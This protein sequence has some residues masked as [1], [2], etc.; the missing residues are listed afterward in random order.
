MYPKINQ[1][2]EYLIVFILLILA[3][4]FRLTNLEN[5]PGLYSDEGTHIEIAQNLLDGKIQYYSLNQSTLIVGRLPLFPI[6]LSVV[7]RFFGVG[8]LQLRLLTAFLGVL[9]I[10]LLYVILKSILRSQSKS[11]PIISVFLFSIYP[12]AIVFHRLGFSYHLLSIFVLVLFWGL[13]HY[14]KT[15]KINFLILSSL[16]LG[17]GSLVDL[18]GFTF[19]PFAVIVILIKN[20]RKIPLFLFFSLLPFIIYSAIMLASHQNA[21]I[22]DL[23]FILTRTNNNLGKQIVFLFFN[24][25]E[26][27]NKD[28]WI[29]FGLLGFFVFKNKSFGLYSFFFFFISF[30]NS[31]RHAPMTG[32]SYYYFIPFFSLIIV[33]VSSFCVY[34]FERLRI[35]FEEFFNN[36]INKCMHRFL[37]KTNLIP[38]SYLDRSLSAIIVSIFIVPTL[39]FSLYQLNLKLKSELPTPMDSYLV[40]YFDAQAA[41]DFVN[42]RVKS[43]DFVIA[44]PAVAWMINSNRADFQIPIVYDGNPSI[45]LPANIPADRF[46]YDSDYHSAKF[47]IVDNIWTDYAIYDNY[48]IGE[49][50][51]DIKNWPVVW[52]GNKVQVHVNKYFK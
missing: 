2:L 26:L 33:G 32:L 9:T 50:Y 21:F 6:L 3:G 47:V 24:I 29:I 8:V 36:F 23:Q 28:K 15:G 12:S 5:N 25:Y 1:Y 34:F 45:H 14:W 35:T 18:S 11:I 7:F 39:V 27:I 4:Y 40:D 37:K 42:S 38:I 30:V 10:L 16:S 51:E 52:S 43:E 49:M 46:S 48:F 41:A 13:W 22:F 44:S 19:F 20:F 31:A 17:L